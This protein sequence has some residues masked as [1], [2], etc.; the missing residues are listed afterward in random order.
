[1]NE[2]NE[3]ESSEAPR[4]S[5]DYANYSPPAKK[6][7]VPKIKVPSLDLRK[8]A[9]YLLILLILGAIGAGVYKFVL[10]KPEK[11]KV[12][13]QADTSQANQPQAS[14]ITTATKNYSSQDFALSFDYPEDWTVADGSREELK[15]ISPAIKLKD[16]NGQLVNGQILMTIQSPNLKIV[17]FESKGNALAVIDS[18]KINYSKPTQNQRASTYISFLRYDGN[19][20]GLDAIYIT[21][22]NGYQKD[23]A[24]PEID[25][26]KVEPIIRIIFGKCA[27]S[28]CIELQPAFSIDADSWNDTN[29]SGPLEAMLQSLV[30]N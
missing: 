20:S 10:N 19:S 1:M 29:L 12:A 23:Q 4:S 21:G 11:D 17:G 25:I 7:K 16:A 28:G 30:I 13:N 3:V 6:S 26:R 8:P 18:K 24:V 2:Q 14:Q 22:D 9:K 5:A 15:V 27:D